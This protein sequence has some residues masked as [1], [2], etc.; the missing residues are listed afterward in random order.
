MPPSTANARCQCVSLTMNFLSLCADSGCP[1]GLLHPPNHHHGTI[2]TTG[3]HSRKSVHLDGAERMT[4]S[5]SN[6]MS[7]HKRMSIYTV[8]PYYESSDTAHP[9]TNPPSFSLS[10]L[11]VISMLTSHTSWL[12]AY[13]I[14]SWLRLFS[15]LLLSIF[16]LIIPLP[17]LDNT[18][19]HQQHK[20]NVKPNSSAQPKYQ[21]NVMNND[22]DIPD[23]IWIFTMPKHG[24]KKK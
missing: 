2:K 19:I 16:F 10:H 21:Q 23:H 14:I 11:H 3:Y 12:P 22:I 9:N 24:Q 1:P 17:N 13:I 7:T 6:V 15:F 8:T 4:C 20:V 5:S 18:D